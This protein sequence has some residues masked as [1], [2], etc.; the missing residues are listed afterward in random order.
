MK[1]CILFLIVSSLAWGL[2][3]QVDLSELRA[4]IEADIAEEE[5]KAEELAALEAQDAAANEVAEVAQESAE[6]A[7]AKPEE[8]VPLK[9]GIVGYF[10]NPADTEHHK[11]L[12]NIEV[13]FA[14]G[15][16]MGFGNA[17]VGV[18]DFLKKEIVID[19]DELYDKIP[20]N[21]VGIGANLALRP[22]YVNV[23]VPKLGMGFGLFTSVDGRFDGSLR[24]N[25]FDL[26]T[27]GNSLEEPNKSGTID[28]SGAVFAEAGLSWR[29]SFLKDKLR[30]SAAPAFFIPL[31]YIPKSGLTFELDAEQPE[32]GNLYL[33]IN[34]DLNLYGAFSAPSKI[35]GGADLSVS[36]EY[37]LFP[38]LDVGGTISHI[39]IVP[40]TLHGTKYT[41]TGDIINTPSLLDGIGETNIGTKKV[42]SADERL[43]VRP[44]RFD[45]YA[46]YRPLRRDLLT[47]KPSIGF[48]VLNPSEEAYFNGVLE[49][50]LHI[51]RLP[52]I[53]GYIFNPYLST[54]IEE[55]YWRHKLGYALNFR[56]VELDFEVG[57]KS[58]DYLMSY[59]ASGLEFTFGMKF[60]W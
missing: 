34:G 12:R 25:L 7:E 52:N 60:G 33:G 13:G 54:G 41:V 29:G 47:L 18:G 3:A 6:I 16:K 35:G 22:L 50:R 2:Y 44:L 5:A 1:K 46:L 57:L 19:L 48:T 45:F 36:G 37:A 10:T 8:T 20:E 43:V 30:V 26:I 51:G 32:T 27:R 56:A 9:T 59:Q 53:P 4:S 24:K 17:L 31:I 15:F 23:Y 28:V 55:G 38:I 42:G 11:P 14:D 21:G 39:P 49:V 40:A 58:Q